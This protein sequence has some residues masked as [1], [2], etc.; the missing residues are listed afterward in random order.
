MRQGISA[1]TKMISVAQY[2]RMSTEHQ[3]Y[4]TANQSIAILKYAAEHHMDIVRTYADHGKSG[5]DLSA[6]DGLQSLLRDALAPDADFRAVLVYDVS[7][8]GRFQNPDESASYEYQLHLADI[9]VHY[10][11][12]P[13]ENDGSLATAILKAIKRGMAGEYSR[14]LSEKV[15]AGNRRIA[16]L[17][18]HIG[19]IA[20]YGLRRQLMGEDGKPKQSLERGDR[21]N[22]QSERVI[23]VP[24]PANEIRIVHKIYKMYIEMGMSELEI[25][26]WLNHRR[27]AWIGTKPW[28]YGCVRTILTN[29]KY[30][31]ASVYNR[32]SR[33]LHKTLVFN[34]RSE[35]IWR[36][37]AFEPIVS[38]KRFEEA[39]MA[40]KSRS[41]TV[42][43]QT[44]L[45]GLKILIKRKHR[46]TEKL[47]DATPDL[48]SSDVYRHRF[49]S[50]R[51]AYLLAGW[52]PT[53]QK[54]FL[55]V[56]RH[57]HAT[58]QAIIDKVLGVLSSLGISVQQDRRKCLITTDSG[59]TLSLVVTRCTRQDHIYKYS[60]WFVA[61]NERHRAHLRVVARLTT[62]NDGLMDFFIFPNGIIRNS[63]ITLSVTS[64]SR[65]GIYRFVDIERLSE[66]LLFIEVTDSLPVFSRHYEE[67]MSPSATRFAVLQHSV[68]Q[69]IADEDFRT[70]LRAE[71]FTVIPQVLW[72]EI[73][74]PGEQALAVVICEAYVERI[75]MSGKVRCFIERRQGAVL[76]ELSHIRLA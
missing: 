33:K 70:L 35:W 56:H 8:W 67:C 19:G 31:G 54:A 45:D 29:P 1:P 10:C 64:R 47:I 58:R 52:Q 73:S 65:I 4:S 34:P 66:L 63:R 11:A 6:R 40:F 39:Q 20:G 15:W 50:L 17:G 76:A 23:L 24:G 12:E 25:A 53:R 49:G 13:F 30:I 21:K 27:I 69:L 28:T 9:P 61:A 51:N 7:R 2:L 18:Y 72:N 42:S 36:D 46:V 26:R 38:A 22:L 43:E 48:A 75:L 32:K 57:L 71:G 3:Q 62:H 74:H 14:E 37:S 55:S 41:K 59:I 44:L 60:S 16:E 68:G 5:L